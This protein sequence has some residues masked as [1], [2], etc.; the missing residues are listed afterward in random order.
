MVT[1]T[2]LRHYDYALY[3]TPFMSSTVRFVQAV[4]TR[5]SHGYWLLEYVPS[6]ASYRATR[7]VRT[8]QR[9]MA[10]APS[11]HSSAVVCAELQSPTGCAQH[12]IHGQYQEPP[13]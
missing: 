4:P 11:A 12:S 10:I 6:K 2:L 9:S 13:V 3:R 8:P 1:N 7:A 5:P